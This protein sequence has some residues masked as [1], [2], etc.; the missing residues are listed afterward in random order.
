MI[1]KLNPTLVAAIAGA[2]AISFT[3]PIE[4]SWR[5]PLRMVLRAVVSFQRY[6]NKSESR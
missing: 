2:K 5:K 6:G 3:V 4:I 1:E